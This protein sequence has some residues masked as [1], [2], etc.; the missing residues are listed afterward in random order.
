[1]LNN[2]LIMGKTTES[3]VVQPYECVS[4]LSDMECDTSLGRY[5]GETDFFNRIGHTD[6]DFEVEVLDFEKNTT[7]FI[8]L[9][10]ASDT[11]NLNDPITAILCLTIIGCTVGWSI[12]MIDSRIGAKGIN[13]NLY[14]YFDKKQCSHRGDVL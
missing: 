12:A 9:P 11:T 2:H 1:M 4:F 13:V 6:C 8:Y 7:R 5:G 10:P 14:D 3:V